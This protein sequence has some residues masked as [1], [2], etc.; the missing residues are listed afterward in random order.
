[1]PSQHR[2]PAHG[3]RPDPG[4]FAAARDRLEARGQTVGAYLRACLRWLARDP[5]SALTAT[6]ADWP[7]PRPPGRPRSSRT[8]SG[9]PGPGTGAAEH[10]EAPAEPKR[11]F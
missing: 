3:F 5:D 9:S 7:G 6:A 2:H 1:V 8:P 10:G 4:E 11:S